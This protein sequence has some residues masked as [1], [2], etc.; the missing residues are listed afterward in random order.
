MIKVHPLKTC[1]FLYLIT[2]LFL[3]LTISCIKEHPLKTTLKE[4]RCKFKIDKI[5]YSKSQSRTTYDD[6]KNRR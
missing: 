5:A 6:S 2:Y 3:F 4:H 1:T